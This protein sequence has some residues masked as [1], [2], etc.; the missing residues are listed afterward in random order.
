MSAIARRTKILA[1]LGP[2]TDKPGVLDA[3]LRAVDEAEAHFSAL[4]IWQTEPPFSY[5][6]NLLQLM[7]GVREPAVH[8]G[9]FDKFRQAA[10]RVK[11]TAAGGASL[12][13]LFN[14][15]T[16]N[17]PHVEDVVAKFQRVS[18]RLKYAQVPTIAAVDGLA[19]GGGCE[20]ALHCTRIV[21]TQE[22][23]IGLV[24][25]GVGL[26]PAG[27]GCKEM[28]MRASSESQ[29]FASDDR[30]DV[31]PFV[32][33]YFQQIALGTVARSAEQAREMGYLRASD[34]IV[35]NRF[36]LLHVAQQEA[37]ALT[38]TSY[39]P[40]LHQRQ[41]AV[42]GRTGIATLT[43]AMINMHEGGF[44]SDHD[45]EIGCRVAAVMCGG[46]VNAGTLVD[47][48]WLLDLERH[49]FLALLATGKTQDRIE[50]MLKHGKA[51]RN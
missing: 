18:Q 12:G 14:A 39:C 28:V 9:M 17:V 20:F 30:V 23:Y 4:I 3:L 31:F 41:I 45:Y 15:A 44:I 7:Q 36:E 22:S 49:H 40:P 10:S 19:L 27:G 47:E 42:A 11:Y 48:Q 1:T 51:L 5:G 13:K 26:L 50:H 35:M 21:A 32:R 33:R 46:E 43:A 16:G 34:R 37:R 2:A 38:A 6:A 8:A 29:R 24:E 25:V